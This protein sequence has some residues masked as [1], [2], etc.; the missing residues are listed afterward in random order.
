[1]M[2]QDDHRWT[3][4]GQMYPR[5]L[6]P[7]SSKLNARHLIQPQFDRRNHLCCQLIAWRQYLGPKT[8]CQP[9]LPVDQLERV[10]HASPIQRAFLPPAHSVLQ[11]NDGTNAE[12]GVDVR[13]L[14]ADQHATVRTASEGFEPFFAFG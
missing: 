11:E 1:M 3:D 2:A 6:A 10:C 9:S 12:I 5:H 4:R 14:F 13:I 8:E 7:T